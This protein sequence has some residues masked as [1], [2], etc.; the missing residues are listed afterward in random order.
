[1]VEFVVNKQGSESALGKGGE[2]L[3]PQTIRRYLDSLPAF[4]ASVRL[5]GV[6][7]LLA[8]LAAAALSVDEQRAL[9]AVIDPEIH[10]LVSG[11][12]EQVRHHALPLSAGRHDFYLKLQKLLDGGTQ[13][14]K[15]L[16]HDLLKHEADEIRQAELRDATLRCIDYLTQQALQA[17][18]VYREAPSHIWSDL[19]RL[20]AYAEKR[21]LETDVVEHLSDLSVSGAYARALLLAIA[22]P[23]HLLQAEIYDA[24][25]KLGKWGL[26]VRFEHP[27]ELPP[28]PLEELVVG[29]YFCDLSGQTEPAYGTEELETMPGDPRL[30]NLDELLRIIENRMKGLALESSRSLKVRAEWDLLLRLRHAWEKRVFRK[31]QRKT[32]RGTTVKA[33]I[34]LSSCHYFFSGYQPFEPEKSE[35]CL[36]GDD[37]HQSQTL[38]LVEADSTPWL[39]SDTGSKLESGVIKPRAYRFDLENKEDDIWKKTHVTTRQETALEKNVEK[40]RLETVFSFK[41]VNSSDGGE[42]LETMPD[43]GVQLR[44]GELV[45]LF[46]HGGEDNGDPVLNIVRWM[47]AGSGTQ[48]LLGVSHIE[49]TPESVAV[50]AL[51]D[52]AIY[53][54]YTRAFLLEEGQGSSIILPPGQ[55][56]CGNTLVVNDEEALKLCKLGSVLESTRAFSRF[57]FEPVEVDAGAS[58]RI[59]N[60]LSDLLHQDDN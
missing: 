1:M 30:L 59:V 60:S 6:S 27:Q 32:E 8:E 45:A 9:L 55:F 24:Y 37:F 47:H 18:A 35:I 41:L 52:K 16:V 49:G 22:N 23:G 3:R 33:I 14:Y 50:R 43:S 42:G 15:R 25:A 4:N 10:E 57:K 53:K 51:D 5:E 28:A 11:Y 34:S 38:S 46:P 26:A 7:S 2:K 19:H 31:D 20:Y 58:G 56:E 13:A 48:I 39:D 29:R 21:Q 44:V 36:H 54:E 12:Q 40:R 17:Y